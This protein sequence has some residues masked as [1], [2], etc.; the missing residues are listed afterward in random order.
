MGSRRS[1]ALEVAQFNPCQECGKTVNRFLEACPYCGADP[2]GDRSDAPPD[3]SQPDPISGVPSGD[4][5][6]LQAVA[7]FV[8]L[9]FGL[10]AIASIVR[11]VVGIPYRSDLLEIAAGTSDVT[12][13]VLL[14]ED[15]YLAAVGIATFGFLV[16]AVIFVIWFWR[17]YANLPAVGRQRTRATSWA[18]WPWLV[19]F[20][21]LVIPYGI[22]AEIWTQS[23]AEAGMVSDY[24]DQ[25]MEP[26]I[27]WWS[28]Y[29]IMTLVSQVGLFLG[30]E[31]LAPSEL[32]ARVGVDLVAS[33]V[34]VAAA[35]AA[36]RF[37]RLTTARQE[38]LRHS[39]A[40]RSTVGVS[41]S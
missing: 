31:D 38:Q 23:R 17:A 22:G 40:A 30:G 13:G 7:L 2:G 34:T 39:I 26:V 21:G 18:I 20:A 32:A 16:L 15:R 35:V 36:A 33:L 12:A 19:P 25:N 5:R 1:G 10:Q 29:V 9:L 11:L 14:A 37:V 24:R 41:V 3:K 6:S 27:S 8:Q 28:L 4:F